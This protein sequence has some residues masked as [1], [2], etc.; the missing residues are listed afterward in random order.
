MRALVV[1]LD[2]PAAM[3]EAGARD[4]PRL[5]AL[6]VAAE[7]AG[8]DAVRVAVHEALAPVRES[9]MHDLR[10]VARGLEL[11][12]A[13]SPSLLKLALEVR[14]DRVV[15]AS[16]PATG[17]LDAPPLDPVALR[18]SVPAALHALSEARIPASVR[19]APDLDAVKAAR[20]AEAPAVE[21][22][23]LGAVDVPDAERAAA[24]VPFADACKL[25]AK[26]RLPVQAAGA[27]DARRARA[28]LAVAPVVET[29][30]AGRPL[31]ARALLVG[32]ERAL[33]ELRAA[34][35]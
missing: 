30:V 14:P 27:L 16:E 15:L 33:A 29:V 32:L 13:P 31:W 9:D 18:G 6:A 22:S 4:E 21:I 2:A 12:M 1:S 23:S 8:A 10:R 24:L 5:A 26:L 20:A 34:V 7:S 19:I 11:R 3:R 25:A 35:D 28:L 17:Q